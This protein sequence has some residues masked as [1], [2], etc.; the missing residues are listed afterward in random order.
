MYSYENYDE[1][2][3]NFLKLKNSEKFSSIVPY[4]I[5]QIYFIKKDYDKV[6]ELISKII[7][8]LQPSRYSEMNRL[9]AEAYF[10]V[11]DFN[12]A[13]YYFEKYMAASKPS[14][15]DLYLLGL[16]YYNINNHQNAIDNFIK[17]SSLSD[18]L[19][20][21]SAYYLGFCYI[22]LNNLNYAMQAFKKSSDLNYNWKLKE[23]SYYNYAKLSYELN[24]PFDNTLKVLTSYNKIFKRS[25]KYNEEISSLLVNLYQGSSQYINAY[26]QLNTLVSLDNDKQLTM[27]NISY[28][29]GVQSYNKRNYNQAIQYFERSNNFPINSE[30]YFMSCFWLAESFY[31]LKDYE[32]AISIHKKIADFQ[33]KN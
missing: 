21:Y 25:L 12:N 10:H 8:D 2:L 9:L 5:A 6:I 23:E 18:S 20:Q 11:N 33:M 26:N 7:N 15:Y 32:K 27:Q 30:I 14:D 28:I 4:Y 3:E 19:M 31:K 1:A 17:I 24:L 22:N 29:L 13:T 16:S